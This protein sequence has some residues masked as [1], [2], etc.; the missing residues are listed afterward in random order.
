M[1]RPGGGTIVGAPGVRYFCA[2]GGGSTARG[3][4][5]MKNSNS[6]LL[7]LLI[8]GGA[9]LGTAFTAGCSATATHQSTGEYI[10]D[11][12]I[13]TKVKSAFVSDDTVKAF[14]VKVDTFRGVVQLSGFVDS[15]LQKS[16]AEEI[17]R[18]TNGVR[19]VKNNIQ[20]K[21]AQGR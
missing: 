21:A 6:Y 12:A 19:D 13:T 7:S 4:P 5:N 1:A 11:A 20:L 9:A 8:I 3:N 15:T 14:D 18:A 2:A 16:R 10:D 17:A